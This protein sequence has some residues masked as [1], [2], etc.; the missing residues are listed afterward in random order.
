MTDIIKQGAQILNAQEYVKLRSKMNPQHQLIF[1]GMLF[2]GMRITEFWRFIENPQW[3][4]SDR[5]FIDLPRGSILKVKAKQ[6]DRTV[7]LSNIGN[8]AIGDL[9]AAI[10]RGE[11]KEISK[12]SWW[13]SVRN[14]AKKAELKDTVRGDPL[15]QAVLQRFPGAEIVDV[16]APGAAVADSAGTESQDFQNESDLDA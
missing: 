7:L 14:A 16:R 9:V 6:K 1:D 8:R 5:Q 12:Q 2:T 11:I 10:Y 13:E 15:V 4:H 3:Y